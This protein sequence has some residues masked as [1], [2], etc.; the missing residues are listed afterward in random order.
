MIGNRAPVGETA[1]FE[2][3]HALVL[4][5]LTKFVKQ[6][7]FPATRFG[8]DSDDLTTASLDLG[9]YRFEGGKFTLPAHEW[10]QGTVTAASNG[11]ASG[12][13]ADDLIKRHRLRFPFD[14]DGW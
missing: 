8:D 13:C 4:Y 14:L 11:R 9:K 3:R 12:K 2:I 7:G 5:A 1:S 10:T 6:S